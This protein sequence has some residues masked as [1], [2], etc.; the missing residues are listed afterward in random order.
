[1]AAVRAE[2]TEGREPFASNEDLATVRRIE[3]LERI[4]RSETTLRAFRKRAVR[5]DSS[6]RVHDARSIGYD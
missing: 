4:E 1:M 3:M 2:I 6:L 5:N